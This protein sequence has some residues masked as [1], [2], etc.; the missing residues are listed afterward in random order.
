MTRGPRLI[1]VLAALVITVSAIGS[2]IA[3][4]DGD[5]VAERATITY[6]LDRK[7][8]RVVVTAS[9]RWTNQIPSTAFRRYYL[10]QWGPIAVPSGAKAFKVQ[11]RGVRAQRIPTGGGFD[12]VIVSF[13][14]I[15]RGQS[16]SFTASWV[17]PSRGAD[18]TTEVRVTDAYSYLCWTGQPVDSGAV[19]LVMPKALEAVT[20]GSAVRTSRSGG[21]RRISARPSG[22][23]AAFYAC[24]DVYDRRLLDRRDVVSPGG[25]MVSIEGWPDDPVW[26]AVATASVATALAGL[27]SVVG[28]PLPGD[29]PIGVRE[30]AANALM[31]YGGEFD[32]GSGLIRVGEAGASA[33]LLAHELAHTWFN[34]R[35]LSTN[36]LWE[37]LAEWTA[38]TADGQ[39]CEPP[40]DYP[41]KGKPR[42]GTWRILGLGAPLDQQ[43]VVEYQYVA[44][45]SIMQQV[46]EAVGPDKMREVLGVLL[47]GRSPYDR[48]PSQQPSA[49]PGASAGPVASADPSPQLNGTP[50]SALPPATAGRSSPTA[51]HGRRT[52]PVDWRQWLD[53]VD[54]VGLEPAGIPDARFGERLLLG[55]GIASRSQLKGRVEAR[56]AFHDLRRLAPDDVSPVIVR[57]QLDDW[58]F[59]EA[60]QS[61][62]LARDIAERLVALPAGTAGLAEHWANYERA[63][64]RRALERVN[65]AIP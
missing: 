32:P 29:R 33:R 64:S 43:A 41:A 65:R 37:G 39:P 62:R 26:L 60:R 59:S 51:S 28:Q 54:E 15:Y 34:D 18:S 24:T 42:L 13:P 46:A 58:E 38:R 12:N 9:F 6:R 61:I 19:T 21:S 36:W 55:Y 22:D 16:V 27:E 50:R 23:L 40:G 11:G 57:R 44:A 2:S 31:G 52:K 45:C 30:V 14:R 47:D 7:R 3:R 1:G 8:A 48:L 25:R 5:K 56:E 10:E 49:E 4:A 20:R 35:G 63:T 53:I 17:L